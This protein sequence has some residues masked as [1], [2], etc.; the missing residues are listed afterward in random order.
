[1]SKKRIVY[2]ILILALCLALL[3]GCTIIRGDKGDATEPGE[4][5]TIGVVTIVIDDR[6][7]SK[8]AQYDSL[9]ALLIELKKTGEISRYNY[10][11]QGDKVYPIAIDKYEDY[12]DG[13]LLIYHNIEDTT[14]YITN[15]MKRIDGVTF[16][17]SI[18]GLDEL[19]AKAGV[20][21]LIVCE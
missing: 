16:R 10:G 9:H 8:P 5:E 1:M 4:E 7:I 11:Y 14:L 19:P 2:L 13:N 21:Y 15:N 3:T 6:E 17:C 12:V 18:V 20:K